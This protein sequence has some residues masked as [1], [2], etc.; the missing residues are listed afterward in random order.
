MISR[1]AL[2]R[3][4]EGQRSWIILTIFTYV[5]P[6]ITTL[7]IPK[8]SSWPSTTVSGFAPIVFRDYQINNYLY[9]ITGM[10]VLKTGLRALPCNL[11]KKLRWVFVPQWSYTARIGML[12]GKLSISV[13]NLSIASKSSSQKGELSDLI[14]PVF[15]YL[16][17]CSRTIFTWAQ[18][19]VMCC[20]LRNIAPEIRWVIGCHL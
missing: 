3:L 4:L 15:W 1:S 10:N 5:D 12:R 13:Y 17:C 19:C 20:T 7:H 14:K 9:A 16:S 2:W 6:R 11:E 18:S 8:W